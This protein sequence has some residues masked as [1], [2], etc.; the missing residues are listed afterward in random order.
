MTW[1]RERTQCEEGLVIKEGLRSE[2]GGL[3]VSLGV[4]GVHLVAASPLPP[5]LYS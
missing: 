2:D 4:L 1:E 5:S 3:G